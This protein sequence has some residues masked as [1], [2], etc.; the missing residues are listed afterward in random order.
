MGQQPL[1]QRDPRRS[2]TIRGDRIAEAPS[3]GGAVRPVETRV[4]A[5]LA[6]GPQQ[7][8]VVG[9][10]GLQLLGREQVL[11]VHQTT[12]GQLAEARY[13]FVGGIVVLEVVALLVFAALPPAVGPDE[14]HPD[15]V[16]RALADD[17]VVAPQA[18]GLVDEGRGARPAGIVEHRIVQRR[19]GALEC[20]LVAHGDSV[21]FP[22]ATPERDGTEA[23]AP[24]GARRRIRFRS[25]SLPLRAARPRGGERD[26]GYLYGVH[27]TALRLFC[28]Y[29]K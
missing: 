3:D 24:R 2:P 6:A 27:D 23:L 20:I 5:V 7:H 22:Q 4:H 10:R 21:F 19:Q 17:E 13:A 14:E 9:G 12:V 1:D 28:N 29:Q 18:A 8:L 16:V 26:R 15:V 25:R 11:D